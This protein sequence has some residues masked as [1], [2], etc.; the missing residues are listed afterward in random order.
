MPAIVEGL[1]GM[2]AYK[3]S[4]AAHLGF[5]GNFWSESA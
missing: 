1:F 4:R 2:S 3:G 5:A